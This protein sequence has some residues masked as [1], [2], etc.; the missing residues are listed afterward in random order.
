MVDEHVIA[1]L[2]QWES[3]IDAMLTC[4]DESVAALHVILISWAFFDSRG[5]ATRRARARDA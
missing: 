3:I 4:L 1:I 5:R 2:P